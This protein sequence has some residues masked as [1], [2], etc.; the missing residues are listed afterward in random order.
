MHNNDL[1]NLILKIGGNQ[2]KQAFA[3]IFDY[4]APRVIGY[5]VKSGSNQEIAEEITQEVLSVVWLKSNKFD[6]KRGNVST[7]I[8]TIARNK[9][10]D[11]FRKNTNVNYNSDDLIDALY[12]AENRE[13]QDIESRIREMQSKLN[14]NEKKLIRMNFFEGKSHKNI[15]Q[16]LEI[17]LGTVK[18]RIRNILIK[19]KNS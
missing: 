11:R 13:N 7:W 19:M 6:Y 8:Y 12:S 2:D 9:R 16:D 3:E 4:F 10:I 1:K 18:S 17:P 14:E 15:S 5:L